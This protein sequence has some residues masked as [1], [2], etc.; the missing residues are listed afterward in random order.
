MHKSM[1]NA[2][3]ELQELVRG[4]NNFFHEHASSANVQVDA[5]PEGLVAKF[6]VTEE[7]VSTEITIPW[8]VLSSLTVEQRRKTFRRIDGGSKI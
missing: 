7:R 2:E 8:D 4:I 3:H 6:T 1:S 5:L